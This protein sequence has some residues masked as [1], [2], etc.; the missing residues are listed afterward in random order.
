MARKTSIKEFSLQ[1]AS[2]FVSP[3]RRERASEFLG[4]LIES[5]GQFVDAKNTRFVSKDL[6]FD[7]QLTVSLLAGAA[8]VV[9]EPHSVISTLLKGFTRENLSFISD[10]FIKVFAATVTNP[11]ANTQ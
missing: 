9:L 2:F 11:I 1:T 6:A 10:C 4:K 7:Y 8:H 5:L 3:L